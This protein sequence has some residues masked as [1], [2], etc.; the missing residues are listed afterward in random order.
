MGKHR[1]SQKSQPANRP[2]PAPA[3]RGVKASLAMFV[4]PATGLARRILWQ[5]VAIAALSAVLGLAFNTANPIGVRFNKAAPALGTDATPTN[6][7]LAL[8]SSVVVVRPASAATTD[9]APVPL[10]SEAGNVVPATAVTAPPML[11][12]IPRPVL[13]PPPPAMAHVHT[14]PIPATVPSQSP[15]VSVMPLPSLPP[16]DTVSPSASALTLAHLNPAPIHW[17]EAKPLVAAGQAVLVDVRARPAY[18][19]GH[20]PGALSLPESSS[21]E[22]FAA[23]VQQH[24]TNLTLIVYCSSTSCSQSQRMAAR[25]VQTY[26]YPSVKFM[27]GG[28]LEYQQEELVN[29]QSAVPR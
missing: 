5:C 8:T 19:A 9:P 16:G 13:P 25:L 12:P 21:P 23:F 26:G 15:H 4:V 7:N 20:I 14:P 17:R 18:D 10:V 1:K 3:A 11:P 27:T 29:R 28:Y 2:P 22:E 24:P 6:F